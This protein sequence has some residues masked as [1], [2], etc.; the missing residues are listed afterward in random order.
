[1][2]PPPPVEPDLEEE[3]ALAAA[4]VAQVEMAAVYAGAARRLD[5][6]PPVNKDWNDLFAGHLTN[7]GADAGVGPVI[8]DETTESSCM[9]VTHTMTS[10]CG[11][12]PPRAQPY[13]QPQPQPQELQTVPLSH[14]LQH[15]ACHER[16]AASASHGPQASGGEDEG[17]LGGV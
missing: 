12:R 2:C 8:N 10:A 15:T 5:D 11:T 17:K 1:M 3:A 7:V 9:Y 6:T 14:T 13:L 4:A 16:S